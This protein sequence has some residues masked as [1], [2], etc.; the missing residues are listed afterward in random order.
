[1]LSDDAPGVARDL[2]EVHPPQR[3]G[4]G[5]GD[6]DRLAERD[7]DEERVALGEVVGRYA[8]PRTLAGAKRSEHVEREP[9]APK[10]DQQLAPKERAD[11]RE[12]GGDRKPR[13]EREDRPLLLPVVSEATM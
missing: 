12:R 10:R 1:M 11:Q 9:C 5:E 3:R 6:D 4:A 7:D 8:E 2:L 13:S